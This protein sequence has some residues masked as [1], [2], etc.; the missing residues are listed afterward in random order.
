MGLF[1]NTNIASINA[2]RNLLGSSKDLSRSFQRL[3]SGLR[4]NSAA[5]D[6]AG[7]AISTRFT[8]QIRG[9][10]QAVRN[11]NDGISM[12][13]TI[14]GALQETTSI[15]QR[16]RELAVQ[17]ASDVNT[18]ADRESLDAEVTQLID[19]L[20]RI[21]DTTTFNNQNVLNGESVQT[22]F[23][24]GA[25]ARE[26]LAFG[27]KDARATSL[28]R[29]AVLTS[30]AVTSLAFADGDVALNGVSIRATTTPD[31]TV[32]TSLATSSAIAKAAAINDSTKHT[33]VTA[34]A[35]E[36][37]ANAGNNVT[38]GTLDSSNYVEINGVTITGFNVSNDDADDTLVTEINA[39]SGKTGVVA[40]LDSNND[41][42][43]TAVDGRNI[44]V[45]TVGNGGAISGLNG[46]AAGDTVTTARLEI[47]SDD[48][49]RITG[50]AAAKAGF[51]S[52]D[53]IVGVTSSNAVSTVNLLSREASNRAIEVIDRAIEQV[54]A[55]RAELGAV[56]NRLES[57]VSN[58]SNVVENISSSRSR[59]LDADFAFE[60]AAL[61]RNQILQQAGTSILAQAN[62]QPQQ[63]LALIG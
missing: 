62:Q 50:T 35:L 63:A 27:I 19:E 31:D 20:N 32:S 22:F 15:L 17:S 40:S 13:Q 8:S 38:A 60:S 48:L 52:N 53:E 30:A 28:G 39:E 51:A 18:A 36:T 61:A 43:L 45:N 59:I 46:A 55:D 3:S 41:L 2:R 58:L 37:V 6:A 33:G 16:I 26:T 57:T 10:S 44:Q 7:L 12:A 42:V 5:D 23:H 1:I 47:N 9:L 14:E 11:T 25:N 34:R 56:Q 49:I 54:S 4:I 21:G 29:A 24:V